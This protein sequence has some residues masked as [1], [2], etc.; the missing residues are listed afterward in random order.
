MGPEDTQLDILRSWEHQMR[1]VRLLWLRGRNRDAKT[2]ATSASKLARV[3]RH[4]RLRSKEQNN[5]RYSRLEIEFH[6][7]RAPERLRYTSS[8]CRNFT[9]LHVLIDLYPGYFLNRL[10]RHG[11][12]AKQPR[13]RE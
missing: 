1:F 6:L 4:R 11:N 7:C 8:R 2:F 9:S 10:Q 12:E 3:L 5:L 13:G